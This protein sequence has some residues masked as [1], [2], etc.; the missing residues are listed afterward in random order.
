MA[1]WVELG[2]NYRFIFEEKKSD[3]KYE[4]R[5]HGNVTLK[6]KLE[7]FDFSSRNRIEYRDKEDGKDG[8]R[9]RNKF[10]VKYPIKLEKCEFSPYVADEIFV[11]FVEEKLNRNRLYVGVDFKILNNLKLDIF[12][13]WQTSEKNDAWID[14]N[15]IG[16]KVKLSF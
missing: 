10:T 12:Y 11:D 4:N 7:G 14:Y 13:L 1:D 3:W 6:H 5:P 16:T 8:W 9:Y 15:V 2:M